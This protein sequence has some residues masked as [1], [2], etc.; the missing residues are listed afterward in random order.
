MRLSASIGSGDSSSRA[1]PPGRDRATALA[2]AATLSAVWGWVFLTM[3]ILVEAR[4][5]MCCEGVITPMLREAGPF[6][7][8]GY[9]ARSTSY[10]LFGLLR[11]L[12]G[13]R[14]GA[15]NLIQAALI[16]GSGYFGFRLLRDLGVGR[17]FA[18][19]GVLGWG[20][21]LGVASAM[22]W[23]ATQHD[24]LA[25]LLLLA[26]L[27]VIGRALESG[28]AWRGNLLGG[29]LIYLAINGKESA[30]VAPL[31]LVALLIPSP[32]RPALDEM[33]DRL[34]I[35]WLPLIASILFP[36]IQLVRLQERLATHFTGGSVTE[37]L[38]TLGAAVIGRE[39][40]SDLGAVI[41][42]S[43]AAVIGLAGAMA[44]GRVVGA[45]RA[46]RAPERLDRALLVLSVGAIGGLAI[47][48]RTHYPSPYYLLVPEFFGWGAL[49][50]LAARTRWRAWALGGLALLVAASGHSTARLVTKGSFGALRR[51]GA[52]LSAAYNRLGPFI[53]E[54]GVERIVLR[55]AEAPPSFEKYLFFGW[56]G[57]TGGEERFASFVARA[58]I[59]APVRLTMKDEAPAPGTLL[60]RFGPGYRLEEIWV[61]LERRVPV[62]AQPAG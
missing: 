2:L 32:R 16:G 47:P 39:G 31:I 36:T 21:S 29:P 35:L 25:L 26:G 54:G 45:W 5:Y 6:L 19:V 50:V 60:A 43:L 23:Q 42:L 53:R 38:T 49:V 1:P 12:I 58:P 20:V 3:P 7:P 15:L 17:W 56:S 13:F 62:A 11:E 9:G 4:D 34:K 52:A 8:N 14:A 48:L 28:E 40:V 22:S 59:T 55:F 61:G 33:V 51:D 27:V 37:S 18:V 24:K 30:F 41:L 46:G 57:E 44:A 10:L